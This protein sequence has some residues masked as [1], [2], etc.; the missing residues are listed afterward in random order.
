VGGGGLAFAQLRCMSTHTFDIGTQLERFT[1]DRRVRI[2]GLIAGVVV[3][4]TSM[5]V[6]DIANAPS[7][8]KATKSVALPDAPLNIPIMRHWPYSGAGKVESVRAPASK[9]AKAKAAKAG[10]RVFTARR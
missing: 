6:V 3:I 10:K 4:A 8:V 1:N 5:I 9:P 2:A 7:T